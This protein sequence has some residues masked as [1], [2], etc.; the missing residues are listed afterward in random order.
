MDTETLCQKIMAQAA[1][2]GWNA[3]QFYK[4]AGTT[5]LF[6]Y[7]LRKGF[8]LSVIFNHEFARAF[9]GEDFLHCLSATVQFPTDEQKL[10]YMEKFLQVD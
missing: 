7:G 10:R 2:G 3:W 8:L 4:K 6:E 9:F 1:K 5:S